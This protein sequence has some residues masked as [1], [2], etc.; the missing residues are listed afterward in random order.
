MIDYMFTAI[1]DKSGTEVIEKACHD[2]V[3]YT[4]YHFDNEAQAMRAVVF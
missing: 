1:R 3:A 4:G 2:V